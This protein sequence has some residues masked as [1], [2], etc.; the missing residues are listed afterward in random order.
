MAGQGRYVYEEG[1]SVSQEGKLGSHSLFFQRTSLGAG[2]IPTTRE[3]MFILG[4]TVLQTVGI[5]CHILDS[6]A[7]QPQPPCTPSVQSAF[8]FHVSQAEASNLPPAPRTLGPHGQGLTSVD[9]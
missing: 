2:G 8:L 6:E 4:D 7:P 1:V 3:V 9:S 5:R